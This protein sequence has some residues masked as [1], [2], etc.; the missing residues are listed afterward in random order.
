MAQTARIS[1]RSDSIIQEMVSLTGRSKVEVIEL[2]LETYRRNE[3]MH[4]LNESYQQMR[5]NKA[6]W[7]EE[8]QERQELEGTLGDGLEEE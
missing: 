4:L 7:D 6:A 1:R 2:A 8:L 3:R 5:S